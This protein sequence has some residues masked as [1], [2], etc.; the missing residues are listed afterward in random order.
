MKKTGFD[1]FLDEQMKDP[2]F[3]AGYAEER[4]KIANEQLLINSGWK[5]WRHGRPLAWII[6]GLVLMEMIKLL[7]EMIKLKGCD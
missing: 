5:F 4:K 6:T 7:M 2:E 3:A 1:K